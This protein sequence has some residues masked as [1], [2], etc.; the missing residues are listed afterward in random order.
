MAQIS[1]AAARINKQL[2][3]EQMADKMGISRVYYSELENGK[4]EIKPVHLYAFCYITGFSVD[5]IILPI[6]ST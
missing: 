1:M 5:D 3:Q 4:R 2:S 6:K